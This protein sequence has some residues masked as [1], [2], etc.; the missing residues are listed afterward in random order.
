MTTKQLIGTYSSG[1]TLSAVYS[2]VNVT[3][4]ASIT[5]F[6]PSSGYSQGGVGLLMPQSATLTNAGAVRGGKGSYAYYQAHR[7]F[8]EGVADPTRRGNPR[9]PRA[10]PA[11]FCIPAA[12]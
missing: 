1:Y 9:A 7:L 3:S 4:K 2:A 12:P 10:A 8:P 11:S 5:G 6:Q